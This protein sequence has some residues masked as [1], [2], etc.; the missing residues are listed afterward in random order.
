MDT[1]PDPDRQAL[2]AEPDPAK[3]YFTVPYHL[4]W[5]KTFYLM[6]LFNLKEALENFQPTL[7]V[8][9][10]KSLIRTEPYK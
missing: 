3:N 9:D 2:D 7:P 4:T 10:S 5:V 1:D 8:C 6:Y